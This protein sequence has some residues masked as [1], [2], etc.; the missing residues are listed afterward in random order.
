MRLSLRARWQ[1]LLF[2][3]VCLLSA[4]CG[5][6]AIRSPACGA[7]AC[8]LLALVALP[9]REG[10]LPLPD[11]HKLALFLGAFC[12]G[13]LFGHVTAP[14]APPAGAI[15]DWVRAASVPVPDKAD[16]RFTDG[17]AVTGAIREN[18]AL[19][20]NRSRLI[21]EDV[22]AA[23]EPVP[24]P[25]SLVLTWQ[26]PPPD[27]ATAGPGQRLAA[28]L[29]LR[30]IHGFANPGVWE[31]EDYW[32]DRG[33]SYR[34]WSK[35]DGTRNGKVPGFRLEGTASL[36][37]RVR[38][39]LRGAVITILGRAPEPETGQ[40][41]ALT[42]AAA[43]IPALLFGDRSFCS[44]ETLDLVARATL[45]HSLALSGMHLGF[46]AA[47]GY[48]AA[49]LLGFLFPSLFLRL[50]R[51]QAGLLLALPVCLLYLWIGGAPP[52]LVRAALMLLFW[53]ILLWLRRPKVLIAGLLWAVAL[54]LLVSPESLFDI[55][56]QLSAASVAGIALVSP[57]LQSLAQKNSRAASGNG[58]AD[59]VRSGLRRLLAVTAG[60]ALISIAAQAAVLPL[61][62]DAFPGTGLWFPLN[63]VW[64]P[65]LGMWVLPMAFAGLLLTAVGL[66]GAASA[67]FSL[68]QLPCAGLLS[69]LHA[70]DAAG[71]LLAPVAL[72]PLF[73]ASAGY[74]LLL[75]C[76][77]LFLTA[78]PLS[79]RAAP[80]LCLGLCLAAWPSL[81]PAIADS[82]DAVRLRLIDVG[83]GQ[84]VAVSWKS[85]GVAGR[86]LIDGGGFASPVFDVGRRI[87]TPV[88]TRNMP[89]RLDWIVNT[90][91]DTDHLQGLLFPLAT[92]GV[93]R[94]AFGPDGL[95][96]EETP[97]L[98]RCKTIL[99]RRRIPVAAWKA[100]ETTVLAPDLVIETLYPGPHGEK[101]S[102]NDKSLV[103]RLVWRG[104]PLALLC[105]DIERK[106]IRLLLDS[107]RSLEAELLV[108]PHH[109]GAGSYNAALYDAVRPAMAL[110]SCG[111]ATSYPRP[112]LK[113]RK[114][115]AERG[116][117]LADTGTRGQITVTWDS[118]LAMSVAYARP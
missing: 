59:A 17:V 73:A 52:S 109:G 15:P 116:I 41:P 60:M 26:N 54:I 106:G 21:L 74:W 100:G 2:R 67:L 76:I 39:S 32:R 19:A 5:M 46:A 71:F 51:Q 85:R 22:R 11:G 103:L 80:L 92:F 61:V 75:L 82:G 36:A 3:Q 69:L 88:L 7:L 105:G 29:R 28:T 78:R 12:L 43:I 110:A 108:L 30:Q 14:A 93:T 66:P 91:P 16:R 9:A 27:L 47:L 24:L 49:H 31:T 98:E 37:W 25:G 62:L 114:A 107:A 42:Q 112:S 55:R 104:K 95:A 40:P 115:L 87:V 13:L 65:V 102:P 64:L 20:G 111:Y 1:P 58:L 72:R 81:Y 96:M 33:A 94:A 53:G 56:L 4:V 23:G 79:R 63:L 70:M 38:A 35:D 10:R 90:H 68:A 89:P 50:P 57:L 18:A 6:A 34:A 77:P 84:A 97:L 45:A 48:G 118:G 99:E 83:Q 8:L 101:L 117:P 86:M 44:P 113:I